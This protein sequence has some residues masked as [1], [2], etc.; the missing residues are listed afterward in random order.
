VAPGRVS[1]LEN[2]VNTQLP[3][4]V[5]ESREQ[6]AQRQLL[7]QRLQDFSKT[8]QRKRGDYFLHSRYERRALAWI[9]TNV[10]RLNPKTRKGYKS[11]RFIYY[12]IL[13]LLFLRL[14]WEYDKQLVD[15][16]EQVLY[17]DLIVAKY[18]RGKQTV[19][20][21]RLHPVVRYRCDPREETSRSGTDRFRQGTSSN[22]PSS[23][24]LSS[25]FG[26]RAFQRSPWSESDEE[27][28][29]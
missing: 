28:Y 29:P 10:P 20:V 27:S 7:L 15:T 6:K 16:M 11:I 24:V 23:K 12:R 4:R 18:V 8:R 21:N 1:S 14:T 17:N 26:T 25:S 3:T 5:G 13:P 9:R 19:V 22:E 2:V